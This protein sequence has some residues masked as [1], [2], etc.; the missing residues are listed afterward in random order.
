MF[1]LR[2]SPEIEDETPWQRSHVAVNLGVH[3]VA[4]SDE[5][6]REG[7][8]Y[9]EMIQN[10]DKIEIVLL[11]VMMGIPHHCEEKH[12][13]APVARESSLP[14]HEDFQK[15]LPA[16]EIIVRLVEYAMAEPC[17]YNCSDEQCI[18]KRVQ[19]FLLHAL[20]SEKPSEY[21]P[22]ENE[23]RYEENRIPAQADESEI[24]HHRIYIPMY[25]KEVK[26]FPII[27]IYS[28]NI[29]LIGQMAKTFPSFPA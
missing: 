29:A 25:E 10:P 3:E 14:R 16:S 24:D 5:C 18:E 23:A 8:G 17:S 6:R 15:T 7:H 20:S 22:A 4:Q 28:A 13:G 2:L 1:R 11:S 12:N 19:E 9:A 21:E 26:H 27:L